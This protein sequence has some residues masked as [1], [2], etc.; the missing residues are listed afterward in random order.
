MKDTRIKFI[1]RGKL[2]YWIKHKAR[3][4]LLKSSS[5]CWIEGVFGLYVTSFYIS[6][7][8]FEYLIRIYSDILSTLWFWRLFHE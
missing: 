1:V 8:F 6:G 2:V 4:S 3:N 7:R 5:K